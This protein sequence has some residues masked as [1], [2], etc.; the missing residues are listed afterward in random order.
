VKVSRKH[1][2][3]GPGIACKMIDKRSKMRLRINWARL[4]GGVFALAVAICVVAFGNRAQ[5]PMGSHGGVRNSTASL[6]AGVKENEAVTPPK[7]TTND[8]R[9][10]AAINKALSELVK[11]TNK[12]NAL[13]K[14]V[15]RLIRELEVP[16]EVQRIIPDE[17]LERGD[18]EQ[19]WPYFRVAKKLKETDEFHDL[20]VLREKAAR[21]A[22]VSETGIPHYEAT[23]KFELMLPD[24][25]EELL[26]KY[27][28][29][30]FELMPNEG[31][32]LSGK[33]IPSDDSSVALK[34]YWN[35][36]LWTIS[37]IS[38]D[39]DRAAERANGI[40]DALTSLI[41]NGEA[42]GIKIWEKAEVPTEPLRVPTTSLP[43]E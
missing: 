27:I 25:G 11:E 22:R 29:A 36:R 40:V 20:A 39:P 37:V 4:S 43:V 42:D 32:E 2:T 30:D 6:F 10:V 12:G 17:G 21:I 18:V 8:I 5:H 15:T 23:A 38:V 34:N 9:G 13:R 7:H 19:F 41:K 33:Y 35:T 14:E 1:F 31:D 24:G 3:S 28:A 26:R 16:R